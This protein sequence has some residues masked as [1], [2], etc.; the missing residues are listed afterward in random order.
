M[1]VSRVDIWM[2][3]KKR[4]ERGKRCRDE[5]EK[6]EFCLPFNFGRK[7]CFHRA[8]GITAGISLFSQLP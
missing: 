4:R 3:R 5:I 8:S 2:R 7:L 6:R 1:C